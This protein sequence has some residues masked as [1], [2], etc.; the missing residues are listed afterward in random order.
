MSS[1]SKQTEPD[2]DEVYDRDQVIE[3]IKDSLEEGIEKIVENEELIEE[4]NEGETV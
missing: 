2:Y 4:Y 3:N 1:A